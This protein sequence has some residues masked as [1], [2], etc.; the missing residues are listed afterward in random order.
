MTTTKPTEIKPP[1]D[2]ESAQLKVKAPEKAW[3]TCNPEL[4]AQAYTPDSKWRNR[5]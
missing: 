3:N 4:V 1:F 5:P 2:E